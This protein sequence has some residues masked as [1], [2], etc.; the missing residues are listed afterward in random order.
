[1]S[2]K[3]GFTLIELLVV[4]AII[5]ILASVVLVSLSTARSK[6]RDAG[7][8]ANLANMRGQAEIY[9]EVPGNYGSVDYGPAACSDVPANVVNTLFENSNV[10]AIIASAGDISNGTGIT[11]GTCASTPNTWA[12]SVP[13]AS[14]PTESWCVDSQG[15]S[16]EQT[17]AIT[18]P[19]CN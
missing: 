3:K 17:G 5:G 19:N 15:S 4:I 11:A 6:A 16:Q 13:L 14:D 10:Q 9:Y 1:M 2:T 8:K 12:V 7:I 18:A